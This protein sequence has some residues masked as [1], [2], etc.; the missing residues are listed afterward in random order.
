MLCSIE[1]FPLLSLMVLLVEESNCVP[2]HSRINHHHYN[3]YRELEQLNMVKRQFYWIRIMSGLAISFFL[4]LGNYT[5]SWRV[6]KYS[7]VSALSLSILQLYF[8]F[9]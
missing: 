9:F 3:Q 8:A 2:V 4:I 1:L 5:S 6:R 7:R